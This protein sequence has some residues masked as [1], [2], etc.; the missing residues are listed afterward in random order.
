M[1]PPTIVKLFLRLK[2]AQ[3]TEN[4]PIRCLD[5]GV[6]YTE[7][8]QFSPY[9]MANMQQYGYLCVVVRD[10][11]TTYE[12]AETLA[13]LW[14]TRTAIIHIEG[15]WGYS[16]NSQRLVNAVQARVEVNADRDS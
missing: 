6:H 2:G 10:A 16:V 1:R 13:G 8:L 7:C 11:T 14:R 5:N 15:H 3:P 9:G 12:I 4:S